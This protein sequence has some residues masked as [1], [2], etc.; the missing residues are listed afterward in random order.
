M[1]YHR[2]TLIWAVAGG[3]MVL[4]SFMR[5]SLLAAANAARAEVFPA[6]RDA[7]RTMDTALAARIGDTGLFV[8]SL[9]F[10]VGVAFWLAGIGAII[11]LARIACRSGWR[12]PAPV[13]QRLMN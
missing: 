4:W 13:R 1:R 7:S 9:G 6:F 5:F 10:W 11:V 2:K 12:D 3:A 8:L